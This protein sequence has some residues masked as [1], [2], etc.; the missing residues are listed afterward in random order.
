MSEGSSQLK[1]SVDDKKYICV[2]QVASFFNS[3][4]LH[5]SHYYYYDDD[6]V[7]ELVFVELEY[8]SEVKNEGDRRKWRRPVAIRV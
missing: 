3:F 4:T 6:D 5:Y 8:S 1:I 2:I 7:I